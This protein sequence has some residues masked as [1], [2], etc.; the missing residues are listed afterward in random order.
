MDPLCESIPGIVGA[1][2]SIETNSNFNGATISF[3][4][5]EDKL[6]NHFI[7]D[8][9]ILWYDEENQ[10]FVEMD[11]QYDVDSGHISTETTHFSRY[12]IV[13]KKEWF[14]A[15]NIQLNYSGTGEENISCN[16]VLA[17]DCSGSMS[18]EDKITVIPDTMYPYIDINNCQRYEAV[19]NFV[20]TMDYNDKIAIIAF[21]DQVDILC[22][23]VDVKTTLK[24]AARQFYN[25][26]GTDFDKAITESITML[27]N[28]NNSHNRII[29]LSDG[30]DNV[31]D[32]VLESAI[33][34]NIKIYTI[35][36]GNSNDRIL[37]NIA[38]KTGGEFFKAYTSDDLLSIYDE[39]GVSITVD[40]TDTDGDGL[41]D[42]YETAGMR[43]QNGMIITTDPTNPDT[44]GDSLP[45]GLEIMPEIQHKPIYFPSDVSEDARQ[46]AVFFKMS[47]NPL[48]TDS[49]NDDYNDFV[50]VTVYLSNPLISDVKKVEITNDFLQIDTPDNLDSINRNYGGNQSWF[51]DEN[52]SDMND[53]DSYLIENG[54][55]G[56]IAS[57]DNILYWQKYMG[58]DLTDVNTENDTISYEEYNEFVRGY[59][60]DYL[61]PINLTR[62]F[63]ITTT[64]AGAVT[65]QPDLLLLAQG[66]YKFSMLISNDTGTWGCMPFSVQNALEDYFD[67]KLATTDASIP[68]VELNSVVSLTQQEVERIIFNS[69]YQD[70]PI[71][72]LT[73]IN[74]DVLIYYAGGSQKLKTHYVT[75]TGISKDNITNETIITVSSWSRIGTVNLNDLYADA[76]ILSSIISL[77]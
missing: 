30:E 77:N 53:L 19:V 63:V 50:E 71:I 15:W 72:F 73:E 46:E 38:D 51:Y 2:Y 58:L 56:I 42:V 57:C 21:D 43:V 16:T 10:C 39:I 45:D 37:Q 67:D 40:T 3:V 14:E 26:G 48:E 6:G 24:Y 34:S 9:V 22:P 8:F 25:G 69:L 29:L 74:S 35:G 66:G 47:S 5:D 11:T 32:S 18:S 1:P 17:V 65:P 64:I 62:H 68:Q 76:G 61:T 23:L 31:Q 52:D 70:K 28:S 54:G 4:F 33:S 12:M 60:E 20:D 13:D 41:Y 36:L 59:A 27:N 75:I 7:E 44:D 49:D 55:C